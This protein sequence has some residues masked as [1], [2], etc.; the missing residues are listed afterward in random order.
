MAESLRQSDEAKK[1]FIADVTHELRTPL[2]VIKGTIETLED[3]ALDDTEGRGPLLT[4]MGRETDRLIRLVNELL[5]LTRADAGSL[6]L[7][8]QPLDL[9]ELARTR[10]DVFSGLATRQGIGLK[11]RNRSNDFSHSPAAATEVA[12]TQVRVLADPDRLSQVIDN[13][14]DNAIRHSPE[15]STIT[16]TSRKQMMAWNVP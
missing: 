4:S 2:T 9:A 7:N 14:L 15:N 13:L 10:C 16:I 8:L 11:V 6:Q 12:T 3:G 1:A 5:V